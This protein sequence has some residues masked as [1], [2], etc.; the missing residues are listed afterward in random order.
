MTLLDSNIFI[1]YFRQQELLHKEAM[2]FM[3]GLSAAYITDHILFEIGT[4]LMLRETHEI[5]RKAISLITNNADIDVLRLTEREFQDSIQIF[6]SQER[7]SKL[8][9]VDCSCIALCNS[10]G[11]SLKTF[12]TSLDESFQLSLKRS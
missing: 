1:A 3:S 4:V 8:S 7:A 9:F 11:F 2:D 6:L 5:A 12:D 10:R